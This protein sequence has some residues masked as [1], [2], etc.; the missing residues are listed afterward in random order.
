MPLI[1][2]RSAPASDP[3]VNGFTRPASGGLPSFDA[4]TQ[5]PSSVEISDLV[6][7]VTAYDASRR[8]I[9]G[10]GRATDS[11]GNLDTF[12]MPCT[13]PTVTATPR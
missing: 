2:R 10:L 11:D 6:F 12:D 3:G 1:S 9:P 13:G 8:V 4:P 5:P 7:S